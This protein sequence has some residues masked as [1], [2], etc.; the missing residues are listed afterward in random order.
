MFKRTSLNRRQLMA[1]GGGAAAIALATSACS[2]AERDSLGD[3]EG[4]DGTI[5]LS[6]QDITIAYANENPYSFRNP[7]TN[8]VE[9]QSVALHTYILEQFGA[10]PDRIEWTDP[11]WDGLIAGLGNTHDIVIAG[12]FV[13]EKRCKNA[14][15]ADPDYV[16]PDA[17]MVLNGNPKDIHTIEDVAESDDAVMGV[18]NG[19]TG[20]T[21]AK[22]MGIPEDQLNVQDDL[23]GLK[24]EL[25]AGRCD[26]IELTQINLA[27]EAEQDDE[28][29]VTEG[30]YPKDENGEEIIGAGAAVFSEANK[31][32]RDQYNEK[33]A[34]VLNDKDKWLSLVGDYGFTVEENFPPEDMTAESL[35][36]E[37][38]Q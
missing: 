18:M 1:A 14:Y 26:A 5:D 23:E 7:D 10:D 27:L 12:M 38:Y 8:E 9:G 20:H 22:D 21:I 29:E 13:N 4:D 31:K 36:P 16:M 15:F 33:I 11:G 37:N 28:L 35:C 34:E 25:K 19:T 24:L 17:M 3:S 30:F 2:K 6:G 32:L